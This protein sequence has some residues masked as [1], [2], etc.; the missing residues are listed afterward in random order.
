MFVDD[1]LLFSRTNLSL[2]KVLKEKFEAFAATLGLQANASKFGLYITGTSVQ[3]QQ[4][5]SQYLEM[6][7]E[8]LPFRYLG[9]PLSSKKLI[10]K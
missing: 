7:I 2:I 10:Y 6:V 9:V 3:S 8:S 1:L 5:I 4:D